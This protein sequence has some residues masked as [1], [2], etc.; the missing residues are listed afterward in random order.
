MYEPL[1]E[2]LRQTIE[3]WGWDRN[4]KVM[5]NSFV[6]TIKSFNQI[7]HFVSAKQLVEPIQPLVTSL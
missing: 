3:V 6:T 4:T 5:T 1:D 7:N 2:S